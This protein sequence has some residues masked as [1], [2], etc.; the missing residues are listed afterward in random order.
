[1]SRHTKARWLIPRSSKPP[2][3]PVMTCPPLAPPT[4]GPA[5]GNRRLGRR[6]QDR[7]QSTRA[8]GPYDHSSTRTRR[9][10]KDGL[11]MAT[12]ERMLKRGR[13]GRPAAGARAVRGLGAAALTGAVLTG[14]TLVLAGPAATAGATSSHVQTIHVATAKV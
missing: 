7:P 2:V 13:Q 12:G 5:P 10:R 11:A 6:A 14:T 9:R 8:S 1:M 3:L 4:R